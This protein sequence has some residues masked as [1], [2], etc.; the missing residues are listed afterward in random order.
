MNSIFSFLKTFSL[1][2][3]V[4]GALYILV[5]EKTFKKPIIYILSLT[6]VLLILLSV[7]RHIDFDYSFNEETVEE[8]IESI[9]EQTALL[10]IKSALSIAGIDYSKLEVDFSKDPDGKINYIYVKI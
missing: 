10:T 3:I 9:N 8:N 6:F 7:P 4:I 2:G 5:P 1:G